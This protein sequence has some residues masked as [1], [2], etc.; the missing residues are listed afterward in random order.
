MRVTKLI[1]LRFELAI[2][3]IQII[4]IGHILMITYTPIRA[5]MLGF[6]K[7]KGALLLSVM[8]AV[9]YVHTC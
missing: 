1:G 4:S 5:D 9:R 6:A 8:G 7:T 2:T 3:C